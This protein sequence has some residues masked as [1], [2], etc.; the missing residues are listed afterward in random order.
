MPSPQAGLFHFDYQENGERSRTHLRID[1]DGSGLLF[2]N[3]SRIMHLNPTA[4]LMAYFILQNTPHDKAIQSLS[5]AF[6]ATKEQL[7]ID[8][9]QTSY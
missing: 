4:A 7:S 5:K 8:Y 2:V 9:A 6:D 1:P 3:A